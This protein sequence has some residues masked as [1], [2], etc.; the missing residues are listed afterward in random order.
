MD[1]Y[2]RADALGLQ[3]EFVDVH[4]Q[5]Q[6]TSVE[7]LTEI[8]EALPPARRRTLLQRA[9]VIRHGDEPSFEL[10]EEA[11]PPVTW[12]V[13]AGAQEIA[14]GRCERTRLDLPPDLPH[15][16]YQ[17]ELRDGI[18]Q[19]DHAPLIVGPGRCYNGDFDRSWLLAVQLYSVRST[20]NW[21]IGDF[22][23]LEALLRFSAE[24]GA[25]GVAL[26]PLHALFDDRPGD[27]SPYS[28]DSR[29]FLNTL[30]IDITRLS[31]VSLG[32]D[33]AAAIEQLRAASL[34]DYVAVA[35]LK[36]RALR[37]AFKAADCR[38]DPDFIAFHAERGEK[39]TRF[40]CFEALRHA[41][42]QPWWEWA[43]SQ[44]PDTLDVAALRSG[45]LAEEIAFIEFCQWIADRQ[46][47]SCQALGKQLGMKIG[48]YLDIAVGVQ[49]DGFD[50]WD[51]QEAISRELCVGAPP[52]ALNTAGQNWG[53][54]GY[55]AGGL[56][57]RGFGPFRDM[58]SASMR[59]AGA[60]RL[61]HVFGLQRLYLVPSGFPPAQGVYVRMPF[62]ALL[63]ITALES[64]ANRC[65]VIGEDLGTIPEGFRDMMAKWGVWSYRVMMFE[66][67]Y[68]T[69]AFFSA[70]SYP[71]D[72]LV[73]FNTHDLATFAGWTSLAD[74]AHKRSIGIDP[75]ETDESRRHA[76][77]MMDNVLR[78]THIQDRGFDAVLTF[79]SAT[80]SRL[81]AVQLEDLLGVLD[82]PNI[83]G[84]VDENPNWRRRLPASIEEFRTAIDVERLRQAVSAR[85][86]S[87]G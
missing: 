37:S 23:D 86:S 40:A 19:S 20:R 60:V 6:R 33:D 87:N 47:S 43:D 63:A 14:S 39:L 31:G 48:L 79:L 12:S 21:G 44:R 56:E 68:H 42:R 66:Q 72:A 85:S 4:G 17:L 41:R 70:Q 11:V 36:Q 49:A 29:Q 67:D 26:N 50:A 28:P 51:E 18:A 65:V 15:G 83:P 2:G 5:T 7:A 24:L 25:D 52:D 34:V 45:P 46:L 77:H 54:A 57:A 22:A 84:T 38:R 59:Y 58:L 78:D 73:T 80:P 82:Q 13:R 30:Y 62:E 53:L 8:V 76:I 32:A 61:D 3:T 35:K 27:C 55:N 71:A 75:G 16:V 64:D 74:L 1:V 10:G 9:P 69:K 81:L